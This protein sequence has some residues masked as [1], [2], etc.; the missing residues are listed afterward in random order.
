MRNNLTVGDQLKAKYDDGRFYAAKVTQISTSAKRTKAPV[1]VSFLGY[2]EER[3][4]ALDGLKSKK[5]KAPEDDR[6]VVD[7][8]VSASWVITVETDGAL[9]NHSVVVDAGKILDILPIDE[10]EKKYKGKKTSMLKDAALMPGFVNAHTHSTMVFLRGVTDDIALREWLEKT[11][12]PLEFKLCDEKFVREGAELAILEMIQGGVTTFNDMYWFPE[13]VCQAVEKTGIRAAIGMIAIEFPFGGYGSGPDE[14]LAKG[15]KLAEQYKE[16]ERLSFTVSLHAPYTC[17]DAT[18]TKGG[19]LSEKLKVPLHI[20]LHEMQEE[21]EASKAG[22][23]E[24]Q[25]CHMS[26]ELCS[27]VENLK[28]L[29]L[30]N[31]RLIAV[32]MNWL[33]PQEIKSTAEGGAS[34]VHCPSSNLKLASGFCE[35]ASLIEA[36]IN[37]AIGTDGASSNNTLDVMAE[38]KLAA[39]LAKGVSKN[40]VAVPAQTALRMATLNGA[41]ALG[42]GDKIGS[43][44]VGKEAD[45]IAVQFNGPAVWPAPNSGNALEGFDPVTHIV[46]SS[47]RDQVS[48]VWVQGKRLMKNR[49]VTT[50][51]VPKVRKSANKWAS[52]ISKALKEMRSETPAAAAEA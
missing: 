9:P 27:P 16:S 37:V 40:A 22:N 5:L 12:W 19:A 24:S 2:E 44:A 20:H 43:L 11:V 18:I 52:E 4:M 1:K 23:K 13:A 10:A 32:H 39:I 31:E 42:L 33:T 51:S 8:V 21:V 36:G 7:E 15:E 35:V 48:D 14:Y 49:K 34:V 3:W 38:M 47:T 41:K 30:L 45:M 28:R 50:I 17:S 25:S 46:Y 26:S 29:G 6:K